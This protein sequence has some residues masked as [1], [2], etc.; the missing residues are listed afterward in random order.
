[1][2]NEIIF[3]DLQGAADYIG[4]GAIHLPMFDTNIN[5]LIRDR[6][7]LGQRIR[8][9]P[10]TGDPS[11]WFEV[12]AKTGGAFVDKRNL[13]STPGA[14]SYAQ[15]AVAIK[16]IISKASYGLFD[17]EVTD[18]QGLFN[19]VSRELN[20]RIEDVVTTEDA[21]LWTGDTAVSPL[22]YDGLL[23]LITKT[24]AITK[25]A[26]IVDGLRTEVAKMVANRAFR[27]KPT[28][29]YI[30]PIALDELEKEVKNHATTMKNVLAREVE[31]VPGLVVPALST[32]AGILPLVPENQFTAT[33]SG[34]DTL[35]R[36]AIVTENLIE[37][38]YVTT[39]KPRVFKL[40]TT[41]NLAGVYV[42][43]KFGAPTVR[44][45]GIAHEIVNITR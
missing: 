45:A 33:P 41:E 30:D 20:D 14:T 23:K 34:A 8:N 38:H 11:R 37:Y 19:L 2:R 40:G 35:Y 44:G 16:A 43:V 39:S 31:V 18:Q 5:D 4:P 7:A 13:A 36:A 32:A 25:A 12:T 28:A 15:R 1:M 29:I 24:G 6:G 9:V 21:A 3:T 17:T 27:V 22:Q 42:I 26:S 10:A